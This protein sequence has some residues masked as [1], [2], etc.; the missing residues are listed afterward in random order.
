MEMEYSI[1]DL[2]D[3]FSKF[4]VNDDCTIVGDSNNINKLYDYFDAINNYISNNVLLDKTEM[5]HLKQI[6]NVLNGLFIGEQQS[7]NDVLSNNYAQSKDL[8]LNIMLNERINYGEDPLARLIPDE[9]CALILRSGSEQQI[10]S[11]PSMH[12][13]EFKTWI[14]GLF[15]A[16][17]FQHR[18]NN[19]NVVSFINARSKHIDYK[20]LQT[21]FGKTK[22]AID[23]AG[24]IK[25]LFRYAKEKRKLKNVAK[26]FNVNTYNIIKYLMLYGFNGWTSWCKFVNQCKNWEVAL[27]KIAQKNTE[28]CL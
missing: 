4:V 5:M 3:N 15:P 21:T 20:A 22:Y 6:Q 16:I 7:N 26:I 8:L 1:I 10:K 9:I 13:K 11:I 12:R 18:K 2:G 25:T 19:T 24:G 17:T 23:Y 28:V 14:G 27:D